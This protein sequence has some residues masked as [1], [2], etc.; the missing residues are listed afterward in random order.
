MGA[1]GARDPGK[2]GA[3]HTGDGGRRCAQRT[4]T[5]LAHGTRHQFT[6]S[7]VSKARFLKASQHPPSGAPHD[8]QPPSLPSRLTNNAP[9]DV[10]TPVSAHS[11]HFLGQIRRNT[12]DTI[13]PAGGEVPAS[14][15][16]VPSV[17]KLYQFGEGVNLGLCT[18]LFRH[19][20]VR[21]YFVYFYGQPPFSAV[22]RPSPSLA[23][24]APGLPGLRE[25]SSG[26]HGS[27]E[28]PCV[29]RCPPGPLRRPAAESLYCRSPGMT[30]CARWGRRQEPAGILVDL[31]RALASHAL[32]TFNQ[33]VNV[34]L[35]RT[36]CEVTS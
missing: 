8:R 21:P 17:Q 13:P 28:D 23:P 10:C 30:S 6:L 9:V 16:R 4:G 3:P 20:E 11:P 7:L 26:G 5:R 27:G 29:P 1:P 18:F 22:I 31:L 19:Y 33:R 32:T 25:R 12:P 15:R 24:P 36:V 34:F 2:E 35:A 14:W